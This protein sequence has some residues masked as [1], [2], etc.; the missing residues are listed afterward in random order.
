MPYPPPVTVAPGSCEFDR[1]GGG[2]ELG[3]V[4]HP[5]TLFPCLCTQRER[6][7]LGLY[8]RSFR[9]HSSDGKPLFPLR[10]RRVVFRILKITLTNLMEYVLLYPY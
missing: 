9:L 7:S 8:G 2:A 6:N 5:G 1:L 4:V 10:F 3:G